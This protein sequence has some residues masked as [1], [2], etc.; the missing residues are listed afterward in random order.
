MNEYTYT[1][2][3]VT[4][5]ITSLTVFDHTNGCQAGIVVANNPSNY[6]ICAA[7]YNNLCAESKPSFFVDLNSSEPLRGAMAACVRK[8]SNAHYN[9]LNGNSW[10]FGGPEAKTKQL[11]IV[12]DLLQELRLCAYELI[13]F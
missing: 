7:L 1:F 6:Y 13:I 4:A 12:D 11:A 5:D 3:S 8:L 9:M 2:E 10:L